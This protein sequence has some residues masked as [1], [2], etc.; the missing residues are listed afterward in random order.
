SPLFLSALLPSPPLPSAL[1]YSCQLSSPFLS[2]P[3]LC[4]PLFT[5]DLLYSCLSSPHL[6]SSPLFISPLVFCSLLFSPY[7]SSV[8]YF[9]L[10]CPALLFPALSLP[11]QNN[12][13]ETPLHCAAQYGH[14]DVVRLLLEE[15]TDP[16]M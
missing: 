7:T 14:S 11:V 10:P 4:S 15:L 6:F 2:S 3:L 1:H 13:N 5:T 12:D 16:T 9:P 8:I